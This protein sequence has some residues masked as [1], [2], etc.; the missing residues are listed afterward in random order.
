MSM[1]ELQGINTDFVDRRSRIGVTVVGRVGEND[2]ERAQAE[3]RDVAAYVDY[4]DWLDALDGLQIGL[5]MAGVDA[6]AVCVDLSAFLQWRDLTGA[7]CDQSAL[8]AF[9]ALS[10]TMRGSR[11]PKALAVVSEFDFAMHPAEVAAFADGRD[12]RG[13][14]RRRRET[15]ASAVAAGRQVAE[16]PIRLEGFREW[17]AC[18]G[19]GACEAALDRYAQLLL[20]HLTSDPAG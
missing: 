9:A 12:Y 16:L 11:A 18:V 19:Q 17:R 7:S 3:I 13:W 6:T 8:D 4:D 20:E 15:R 14:L 5:S 10:L 1:F 2:F